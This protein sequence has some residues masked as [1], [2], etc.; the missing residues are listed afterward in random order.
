M[1]VTFVTY[2]SAAHCSI[3]QGEHGSH[4]RGAIKLTTS[5]ALAYSDFPT[6]R[7]TIKS[8]SLKVSPAGS[9]AEAD[10]SE[11]DYTADFKVGQFACGVCVLPAVSSVS[12]WFRVRRATALGIL[13]TGSSIGANPAT[14]TDN[15]HAYE[16]LKHRRH[17]LPFDTQQLLPSNRFCM[18]RQSQ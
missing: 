16:T 18:D 1:R 12:H 8:S 11:S 14:R 5:N 4:A 7:S 6:L 13:A 15:A 9:V 17:R 3:Q 10:P 2:S